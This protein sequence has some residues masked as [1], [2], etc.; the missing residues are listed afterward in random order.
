M[1]WGLQISLKKLTIL[2]ISYGIEAKTNPISTERSKYFAVDL[3]KY[4]RDQL[5]Q[6]ESQNTEMDENKP[7]P[8]IVNFRLNSERDFGLSTYLNTF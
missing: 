5:V 2:K 4:V 1:G 6:L 8:V 3:G 7:L